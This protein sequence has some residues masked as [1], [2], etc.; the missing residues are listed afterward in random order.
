MVRE[1]WLAQAKAIVTHSAGQRGYKLK[2][3][4]FMQIRNRALVE[5]A[6]REMLLGGDG[7]LF[8]MTRQNA[9]VRRQRPQPLQRALHLSWVAAVKIGASARAVKQR[10]A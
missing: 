1:L 4:Q 6:K 9:R 2:K 8:P 3:L 7:G 10:I 5:H